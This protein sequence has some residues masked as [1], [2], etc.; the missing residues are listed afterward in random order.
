[1][2]QITGHVAP[3]ASFAGRRLLAAETALHQALCVAQILFGAF[4]MG[5]PFVDI[6]AQG[7]EEGVDFVPRFVAGVAVRPHGGELA[8]MFE[9]NSDAGEGENRGEAL[10]VFM[11]VTPGSPR[12]AMGTNQALFF[13]KAQGSRRHPQAVGDFSDFHAL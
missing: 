12:R 6:G 1:M 11:R 10:L 13:V 4:Q 5:A 9:G 8:D 3:V 2:S 7:F